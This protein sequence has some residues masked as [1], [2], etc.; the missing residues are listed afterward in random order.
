MLTLV[1]LPSMAKSNRSKT[2]PN[3]LIAVRVPADLRDEMKRAAKEND[4]S[5][6]GEV[7]MALRNHVGQ[8]EKAAA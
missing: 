5:F 3:P 4:R 7:R 1:I 8:D 6:S 2:T